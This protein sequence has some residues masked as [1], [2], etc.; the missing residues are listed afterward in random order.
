MNINLFH[1]QMRPDTS[2]GCVN[3]MRWKLFFTNV[4]KFS[5]Q[6]SDGTSI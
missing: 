5:S 2:T 3:Y 1:A 4:Q 6:V